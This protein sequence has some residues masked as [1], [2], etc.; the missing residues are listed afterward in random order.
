MRLTVTFAF[1]EGEP[2][3]YRDEVIASVLETVDFGEKSVSVPEPGSVPPAPARGPVVGI[4]GGQAARP[5]VLG[6]DRPPAPHAG[7]RV[8]EGGARHLDHPVHV[9]PGGRRRPRGAGEGLGRAPG[10][11]SRATRLDDV[12][13]DEQPAVHVA[14]EV[15]PGEHVEQFAM[16]VDGQRLAV[17]FTFVDDEPAALR[18]EVVA[19]VVPTIRLAG[20]TAAQPKGGVAKRYST[21]ISVGRGPA[22]RSTRPSMV[23]RTTY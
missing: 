1:A 19:S 7:R 15:N 20:L 8:P 12:V 9:A 11:K 16:L 5:D 4:S 3:A 22:T 23:A 18:D 13:I 17:T 14:G 6:Q 10:W 2:R 21:L